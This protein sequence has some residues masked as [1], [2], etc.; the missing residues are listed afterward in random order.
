MTR[1]PDRTPASG[2]LTARQRLALGNLAA[3]FSLEGIDL[4][5]AEMAILARCAPDEISRGQCIRQ[6]DAIRAARTASPAT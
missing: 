2:R 5:F 1:Q 3:S 4:D 6:L